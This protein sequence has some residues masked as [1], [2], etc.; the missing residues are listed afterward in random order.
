RLPSPR[1]YVIRHARRLGD[2]STLA[3]FRRGSCGFTA[4][5]R[6]IDLGEEVCHQCF[7]F[8]VDDQ[9]IEVAV[10]P[11]NITVKADSE[12]KDDFSWHGAIV[13]RRV[14]CSQENRWAEQTIIADSNG[15]FHLTFRRAI[16]THIRHLQ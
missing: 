3:H 6:G 9:K 7:T 8:F 15:A 12:T 11:R 1:D 14:T 2:L 5:D 10:A 16:Y 4:H 13:G